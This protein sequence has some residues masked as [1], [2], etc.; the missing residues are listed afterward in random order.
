MF[1]FQEGELSS[2]DASSKID[3][4]KL[5]PPHGPH[6][7]YYSLQI[8]ESLAY[9]MQPRKKSLVSLCKNVA[10]WEYASV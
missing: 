4:E 3:W 10:I 5:L 1:D 2:G 7:L 6:R 9:G 8:V